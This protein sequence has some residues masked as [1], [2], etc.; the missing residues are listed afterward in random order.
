MR[1]K[2]FVAL[3]LSILAVSSAALLLF[4][5]ALHFFT[6]SS[7][8]ARAVV[9]LDSDIQD[10]RRF[11]A[12]RVQNAPPVF[13]FQQPGP[14]LRQKIAPVFEQ[15]AAQYGGQ[16]K[17]RDF[18]SLLE[19]SGTVAFLVI[20]DD[21][22]LYEGYFHGY[23][24]E[25][26][27][28]SFS[29]SK[30]FLSALVGIAIQEGFIANLE[31]PVTSYA[32]E[33]LERDARYQDIRL[34]HLLSMSSGIRYVEDPRPWRSDYFSIYYAPDLRAV[35]LSSPIEA[36]PGRAFRYN[37]FNP[38]LIGLVLERATGM[39]VAEYLQE[40]I[41]KPLGM[42]ASGSW[43]LDS[44]ASGFEK[45]ESGLNGRAID[46]AKFG[47]LYLRGGE[48]NGRQIVP[49]AWVE[50]STRP[51]ALSDPNPYYQYFWWLNPNQPGHF[52]AHGKLGQYIYIVPEQKLLIV[53]FGESERGQRFTELFEDLARRLGEVRR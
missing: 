3:I 14:E 33:L 17:R 16:A 37:N 51:D 13:Y 15:V 49:A 23:Q 20:Q 41:W 48:W 45:M 35:A 7:Q 38:L 32:P 18:K 5:G 53:R 52:F 43:S 12:R 36:A 10:Y 34:R 30:S 27:V 6:G 2:R 31:E 9:W 47:R 19:R 26:T 42:E 11:P 50:E 24:R 25:S 1:D 8:L 22:L 39:H 46:F 28:T 44:L 29:I 40:K 21:T 4:W